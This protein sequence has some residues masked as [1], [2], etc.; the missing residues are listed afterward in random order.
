MN[1]EIHQLY[2]HNTPIR[3]INFSLS[4]TT[5][6]SFPLTHPTTFSPSLHPFP[7]EMSLILSHPLVY[8]FIHIPVQSASDSVLYDMRREYSVEDFKTLVNFIKDRCFDNIIIFVSIIHIM[9]II[10]IIFIIILVLLLIFSGSLQTTIK[11]IK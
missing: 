4:L 11:Q 3:N 8:S 5:P 9:I 1:S 7:Q 10:I 6:P 2:N